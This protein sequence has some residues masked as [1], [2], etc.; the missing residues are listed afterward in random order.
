MS[1]V[2]VALCLLQDWLCWRALLAL[3]VGCFVLVLA[4]DG[5]LVPQSS[6]LGGGE[7]VGYTQR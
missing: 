3:P 1:L 2:G 5:L 7:G 6:L 4:C